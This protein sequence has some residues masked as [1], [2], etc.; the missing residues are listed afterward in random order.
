ME[1][2]DIELRPPF[3]VRNAAAYIVVA[4]YPQPLFIAGPI[5]RHSGLVCVS[6]R[7]NRFLV[8]A[9]CSPFLTETVRKSRRTKSVTLTMSGVDLRFNG[10]CTAPSSR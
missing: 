4:H 7:D 2:V 8:R 10:E 5:E 9:E 1:R 6:R 3:R